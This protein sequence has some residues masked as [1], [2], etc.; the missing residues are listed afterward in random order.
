MRQLFGNMLNLGAMTNDLM[1]V[2]RRRGPIVNNSDSTIYHL[3]NSYKLFKLIFKYSQPHSS[4]PSITLN[5]SYLISPRILHFLLARPYYRLEMKP[6]DSR[7]SVEN[8]SSPMECLLLLQLLLHL[9]LTSPSWIVLI[10]MNYEKDIVPF[11]ASKLL[12]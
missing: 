7:L 6:R 9:Y 1:W 4:I 8:S 10:K 12:S 5:C 11:K 3:I 2:W